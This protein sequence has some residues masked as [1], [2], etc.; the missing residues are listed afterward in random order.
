[1]AWAAFGPVP[2]MTAVTATAASSTPI[3]SNASR[4]V[5]GLKIVAIYDVPAITD[6]KGYHNPFTWTAGELG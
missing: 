5:E 1:M 4:G 6:L 3:C 2:A